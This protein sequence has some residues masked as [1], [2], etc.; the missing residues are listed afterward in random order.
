MSQS[1]LVVY[2][3][4]GARV[5]RS[6]D[7]GANCEDRGQL[8]PG[9]FNRNILNLLLDPANADTLYAVA[10]TTDTTQGLFVSEDGGAH[11]TL[12]ETVPIANS[13]I[14]LAATASPRRV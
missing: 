5:F 7:R 8:G 10:M 1:G 2:V 11:W 12:Q 3:S 9:G 6:G 13:I 4:S 14:A